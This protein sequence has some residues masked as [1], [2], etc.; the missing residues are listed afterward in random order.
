MRQVADPKANGVTLS[1]KASF[2]L[3]LGVV[4][5]ALGALQTMSPY[6]VSEPYGAFRTITTTTTGGRTNVY[7]TKTMGLT[8]VNLNIVWRQAQAIRPCGASLSVCPS[9]SDCYEYCP[10]NQNKMKFLG[11][12]YVALAP[13][14]A[15]TS[16]SGVLV[17]EAPGLNF[18][19]SVPGIGV[20]LACQESCHDSFVIGGQAKLQI[21]VTITSAVTKQTWIKVSIFQSVNPTKCGVVFVCENVTFAALMSSTYSLTTTQP[22]TLTRSSSYTTSVVMRPL[23]GSESGLGALA[24][25]TI[26]CTTIVVLDLFRRRLPRSK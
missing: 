6:E 4:F 25:G 5:L 8:T 24:T 26:I 18:T 3:L 9:G 16:A 7:V 23:G 20:N 21:K 1:L 2:V 10:T 17:A 11:E 15:G 19:L 12:F 13:S 22:Q 14:Y